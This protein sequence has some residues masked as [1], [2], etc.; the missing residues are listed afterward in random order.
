MDGRGCYQVEW[1]AGFGLCVTHLV[2]LL[3]LH[4]GCASVHFAD[5]Q[6]SIM[7]VPLFFMTLVALP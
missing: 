5:G 3:Q 4:V 6:L 1:L 7:G 2:D